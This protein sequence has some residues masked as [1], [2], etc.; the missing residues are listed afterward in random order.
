MTLN[1]FKLILIS[2]NGFEQCVVYTVRS[3]KFILFANCLGIES[4]PI[5]EMSWKKK[6]KKLVVEFIHRI[7][8]Q[9]L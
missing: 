3:Y 5:V 9:D 6:G 1:L 8:Q 7:K 4:D 2:G